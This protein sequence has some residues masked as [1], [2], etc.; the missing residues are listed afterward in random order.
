MATRYKLD[1]TATT[2]PPYFP[3]PAFDADWGT[4]ASMVR[5]YLAP[6]N[7]GALSGQSILTG[8]VPI[9]IGFEQLISDRIGVV[10]FNGT[11]FSTVILTSVSSALATVVLR[12]GIRLWHADGTFTTLIANADND[13]SWPVQARQATR[14][15]SAVTLGN[16]TSQ[17]GDRIIVEIGGNVSTSSNKTATLTFGASGL[18]YALTSGLTTL[19]TPWL[20]FSA[21][22]PAAPSGLLPFFFP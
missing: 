16:V 20:E 14:I 17:Y 9:K 4:T 21:A 19:L 5:R 12:V 13:T 15:A 6:G 18:D 8:T 1:A 22:I 7:E 11:T 3:N 2:P 10:N